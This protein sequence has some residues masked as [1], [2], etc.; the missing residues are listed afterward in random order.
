MAPQDKPLSEYLRQQKTE[1]DEEQEETS[2]KTKPLHGMYHRQIEGVAD[3]MK[4]YQWLEKA[5]LKDSNRG[6]DHG[7]TR[8]GP[9]HQIHRGRGLPQQ[10]GPTVQ[11]ET[12]QHIVAGCKM[13]AGPAYTER[14]TR[15]LG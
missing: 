8:A 6:S 14:L 10:T 12:V 1:G 11:A 2:W 4:S 9:Q 7:S 13:L 3:I 15:W 5:G